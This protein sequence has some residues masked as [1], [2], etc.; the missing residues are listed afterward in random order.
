MDQCSGCKRSGEEVKLFDGLNVNSIVRVCE[1][2]SIINGI[3]IIKRP[4]TKQLRESEQPYSVHTR[5]ARLAHMEEGEKKEKTAYEVLKEIDSK[6]E[7]E[8]PEPEDLVFKLVDNFHWVIQT[9]RRRK[10]LSAKQL[11]EAI[12]ES[13]SA[14]NML[15]KGIVPSRS[16]GMIQAIEQLLKTKLVKRDLFEKMQEERKKNLT[17]SIKPE[18]SSTP[19]QKT[20]AKDIPTPFSRKEAESF[21][22]RDLQRLNEK[23]DKDFAFEKKTKEEV[24]KEQMEDIGKE[25]IEYLKKTVLKNSQSLQKK[26]DTPKIYDLMKKKEEKDK[27]SLTGKDIELE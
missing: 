23:I 24:G 11:A 21:K 10:G 15:E 3:P 26:P 4:S 25:D 12:H 1:R 2:C 20:P 17:A 5:L 7:L 9:E 19:E 6:P 13:E 18:A 16:L 27:S 8:H 22:M 14:I